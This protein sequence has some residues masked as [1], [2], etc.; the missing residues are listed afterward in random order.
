MKKQFQ[1]SFSSVYRFLTNSLLELELRDD[2]YHARV[3]CIPCYKLAEVRFLMC[4]EI[5]SRPQVDS[6]HGS[7][8]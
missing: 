5:E 1:R 4:S 7:V 2:P 8:A 3:S 6:A